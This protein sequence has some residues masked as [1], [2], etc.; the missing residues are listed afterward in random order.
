M[1][2]A[3]DWPKSSWR[4]L[5]DVEV[6]ARAIA[7]AICSEAVIDFCVSH[8]YYLKQKGHTMSIIAFP[9]QAS[10]FQPVAHYI[11][12]GETSYRKVADLAAAGVIQSKRF[13]LD[14]S[15]IAYQKDIIQMLQG[16]GAE[17]VLDPRTI[18]LSARRKCAG[19]AS[20][21]PWASEA[22]GVPL[23]PDLFRGNH[24]AD[25]Y[26]AIAR[27]A[28]EYGVSAVLSLSHYLADP[29]FD[30]WQAIDH[31]ACLLLRR[32]LNSEGGKTI[33]IDYLVAAR[34]TD[35]MDDS[36]QSKMMPNLSDLPYDNLWV[37]ASMSTPIGPLNA[38]RLVRTLS[39]WHNIG[40]P[41]VMDYMGGLTA[42]ALVGMNVVSGISHGYGEQSSFTTAKWTDPPEERDKDKPGGRATRVGVSALGCTFNSAELD[43]LLS[44]HGAKS[45][46]LPND[47][48]VLPNGVEDIR[49][50]PRR[51]NVYD[52]QR[53]MAEINAV[54][55]VN[56]PDH[57]AD[58]R[59]REVVATANKAAKLNPKA[60]IAEAKKVDLTKLR[61]RLVKFS[62]ASEKL[63]GTYDNLAQE[64]TEQGATVRAIGDLRRSTPLNQ[65]GTQ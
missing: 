15:K 31:D 16:L 33:A 39:R 30:G 47:R 25:I 64:R 52:A 35:F 41:I 60:D 26:G 10:V 2:Q 6:V 59:M 28:V 45:V 17:V 27:C 37:R 58:K 57:F 63:R 51:F 54:P 19:L 42:E 22:R 46:L 50:D 24:P 56:R 11:R 23:S 21:A 1:V 13:V 9:K 43:V 32:A 48:K 5:K 3:K 53:R 4:P 34:L 36:F 18:E 7:R 55:T 20:T 44:A 61:T 62:T 38:Q 8:T 40:K 29:G 14:G 49:R 12:L 65:T